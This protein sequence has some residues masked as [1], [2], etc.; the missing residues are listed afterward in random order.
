MPFDGSED[1]V[2]GSIEAKIEETVDDTEYE[3]I[4]YSNVKKLGKGKYIPTPQTLTDAYQSHRKNK[5]T[6]ELTA[7]MLIYG[8]RHGFDPKSADDLK[9]SKLGINEVR[10]FS[11]MEE[12]SQIG[13]GWEIVLN[14]TLSDPDSL[15][16]EEKETLKVLTSFGISN[17]ATLGYFLEVQS[18]IISEK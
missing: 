2:K 3:H 12:L 7:T 8:Y 1:A 6:A 14:K 11:N 17:E 9:R 18:Q 16:E 5:E 13:N 15:N 10:L 4:K